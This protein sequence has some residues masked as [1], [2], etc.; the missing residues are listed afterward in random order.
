VIDAADREAVRALVAR[1]G[2]LV[3]EAAAMLMIVGARSGDVEERCRAC[4]ALRCLDPATIG[5]VLRPDP[6]VRQARAPE[7]AARAVA[8][9]VLGVVD[10]PSQHERERLAS[11]LVEVMR[12]A[13]CLAARLTLREHV[14]ALEQPSNSGTG[15]D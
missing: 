13:R 4:A 11:L 8:D 3:P 1:H 7:H 5:E 6:A 12:E 15:P 9:L 2:Y 14:A 10:E